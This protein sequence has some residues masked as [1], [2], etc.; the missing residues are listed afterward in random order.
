MSG[1]FFDCV[2]KVPTSRD[3]QGI[4][5]EG[6]GTN[7]DL[8]FECCISRVLAQMIIKTAQQSEHI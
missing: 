2:K 5:P 6:P 7:A 4:T 3:G 1:S 8:G